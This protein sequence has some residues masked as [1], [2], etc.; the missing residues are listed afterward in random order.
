MTEE[1]FSYTFLI[2]T[3][4]L[5]IPFTVSTRSTDEAPLSNLY[6]IYYNNTGDLVLAE[7]IQLSRLETTDGNQKQLTL[8]IPAGATTLEMIANVPDDIATNASELESLLTTQ[9]AY[10][11]FTSQNINPKK[12]TMYAT[13]SI[14]QLKQDANKKINL[15]Y[16]VAKTTINATVPT[17]FVVENVGVRNTSR[18]GSISGVSTG[19]NE[20]PDEVHGKASTQ[21]SDT[22]KTVYSYET[23]AGKALCLN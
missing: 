1:T 8:E 5:P 3:N 7:N 10:Q 14:A 16:N 19:V 9:K 21:A 22:D 6:N 20:A 13:S 17:G 12:L 18:K 2:L 4:Y 15:I 23:Q 11:L